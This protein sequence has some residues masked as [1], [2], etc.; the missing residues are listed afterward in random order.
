MGDSHPR[1]AEARDRSAP[2]G[3][4][5]LRY[6]PAAESYDMA[7]VRLIKH[8]AVVRGATKSGA[9]MDGPPGSSDDEPGAAA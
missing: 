9:R 8:E 6:A 1:R 3:I 7:N 4:D 5:N 2:Q